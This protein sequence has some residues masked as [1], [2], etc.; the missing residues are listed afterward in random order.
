MSADHPTNQ[1]ARYRCTDALWGWSYVFERPSPVVRCQAI[2]L[3]IGV[4][5]RGSRSFETRHRGRMQTAPGRVSVFDVGEL[6][7][8]RYIP[9]G[10]SGREIG[11]VVRVDKLVGWTAPDERLVF[12]T[13]PTQGDA[14]LV[15]LAEV[16]ALALDRGE[17]PPTENLE[18]ELKR[19]VEA[20]ADVVAR[21][22]LERA[23]L[24][25]HQD[26]PRQHYMRYFADIV[27]V[28]EDTFARQFSA[29]YGVT[30]TK[31][32]TQVRLKEAALMLATRPGLSVRSVV[33]KVGFEDLAYFH[34]AFR[35]Q[36]GMT[37]LGLARGF[38]DGVGQSVTSSSSPIVSSTGTHSMRASALPSP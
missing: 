18:D 31:Y 35:K 3:E 22:A 30:P 13:R 38:S 2:G 37:P 26:F 8:T 24:A 7:A 33:S 25:I 14:R 16:T 10:G 9:S 1:L 6:Y 11:F 4:T 17:R 5:L 21:D 23:R 19:F 27:G 32:R 12:T 20:N 28:H 36:F 34:R 15:E 29:R